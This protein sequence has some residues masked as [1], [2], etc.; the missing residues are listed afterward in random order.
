MYKGYKNHLFY[1]DD[2]NKSI[3][4]LFTLHKCSKCKKLNSANTNLT[5]VQ[6]C[7]YCGN[8]FYVKMGK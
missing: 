7:M 5:I 2:T 1:K 6:C 3:N 4:S 8:P